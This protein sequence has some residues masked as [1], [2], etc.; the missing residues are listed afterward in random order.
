MGTDLTMIRHI[1]VH[2]LYHFGHHA[3]TDAGRR[4]A[5]FSNS[6][7]WSELSPPKPN[8]L[9][10]G[11]RL[12]G[13]VISDRTGAYLA[14]AAKACANKVTFRGHQFEP[15]HAVHAH[16]ATGRCPWGGN[17]NFHTMVHSGH[18]RPCPGQGKPSLPARSHA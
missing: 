10:S 1:G 15:L 12:P 14:S 2:V 7:C 18:E 17:R 4:Q 6:P 8:R 5:I 13:Q 9:R 11:P 3:P 16:S